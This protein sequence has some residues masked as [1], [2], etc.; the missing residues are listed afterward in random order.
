MKYKYLI[1]FFTL[2]TDNNYIKRERRA[3]PFTVVEY[4][5]LIYKSKN[6]MYVANCITKKL[7]G[8]G[9]S[10]HIAVKN[11]ETILNKD[12]TDFPVRVKPVYK[13]LSKLCSY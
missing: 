7:V 4:P 6:N 13:F 5:A 9:K 12:K 8:Y 3:M 10:E 2:K 1:Q 11:L